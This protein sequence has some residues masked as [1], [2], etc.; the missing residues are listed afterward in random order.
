M[1]CLG[2][3]PGPRERDLRGRRDV[4]RGQD[5]V[6]LRQLLGRRAQQQRA[7]RSGLDVRGGEEGPQMRDRFARGEKLQRDRV[8]G[9]RDGAAHVDTGEHTLNRGDQRRRS[10]HDDRVRVRLDGETRGREQPT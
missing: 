4:E 2:G 5:G 6:D 9:G 1:E 10:Q 3:G 8:D 7:V